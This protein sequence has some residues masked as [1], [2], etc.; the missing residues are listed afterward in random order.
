MGDMSK[1]PEAVMDKND[2]TQGPIMKKLLLFALPVVASNL[3]MQ[4]YNI[5]DSIIVG[6]FAANGAHA[7]AAVGVSFPVMTLFNALFMGI[8]MGSQ[9]VISQMYGAKDYESLQKGL[10]TSMSL[11][12]AMGL[13]ITVVGTPLAGPLLRMLNTPKELINDATV[14]LVV[15]FLGMLGNVY[16]NL[17]SGA[18]RGMG[19]SKWPLYA[20]IVSSVTNVVLDLVF[21]IVFKWGV[22]GVALATTISH[23]ASGMVLAVRINSGAYPVKVQFRKLIR[24]DRVSVKNIMRLGLPTG[25]QQMAMSLGSMVIQTFSNG[26]GADLIA[27]NTVIMKADGFAVMPMFAMGAAVTTFVGQNI[28]AGQKERAKKGVHAGIL[29]VTVIGLGVGIALWFCGGLIMELFGIE[30][31]NDIMTMGVNGVRILAFFYCFMGIDG[32][33]AGALRGAGAAVPPMITAI[34]SN[35]ARIPLTYFL[36]VR[37]LNAAVE[38]LMSAVPLDP[39][40]LGRASQYIT[41]L[42]EDGTPMYDSLDEATQAAGVAVANMDG[43]IYRMLFVSMAASMVLGAL[44]SF[45]YFKFGKWQDKGITVQSKLADKNAEEAK[46]KTNE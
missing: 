3:I 19:D 31:G 5:A 24:P 11:A 23:F 35:L 39:R 4:L 36:A 43:S 25:L 29:A 20:M 7:L 21:V 28:G 27:A 9:I 42:N 18:L 12:F 6:N 38:K 17:G 30:P 15:V 32:A 45:L 10:N 1:N 22:F 40:I 46:A 26:F 14:Y 8:A 44:L 37:P 16:F 33:I 34:A 13:I 2:L 41:K